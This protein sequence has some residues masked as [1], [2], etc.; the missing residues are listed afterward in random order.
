MSY[1]LGV[2]SATITADDSDFRKKLSGLEKTSNSTFKKIAGYAAAYLTFR[3]IANFFNSTIKTFSDLQEE[4]NK[5]NVVF[6]GMGASTSRI[7]AELRKDFG[8]SELAARRMLAGTGDILTGFGFDRETALALSEGAAKLGADIASFS[9]YS[10]GAEG[11]TNA[12]TKAMLGETESAKMLGVVIR[13]DDEVYKSFIQQAMTTGVK[14]EALNRTF[15]V[16]TEQQAKAVAALA[17][18][19]QQSPNAIGDFVRSQSSLANQTKILK[20]NLEQLFTV[21]GEDG[22]SVYADCLRSVNSLVRAYTELDPALRSTINSATAL[23]IAMAVLGKTGAIANANL[24]IIGIGKLISGQISLAAATSKATVALNA[25]KVAIGPVGLALAGVSAIY[26]ASKYAMD[27][28]NKAIDKN[29]DS[30]NNQKNKLEE[31]AEAHKREREESD[32]MFVSLRQM[33]E[34]ERM[35]NEDRATAE[36]MIKKLTERYGELGISID[37]TTGKINIEA[38]A[39]KKL[40]EAQYQ[41]KTKDIKKNQAGAEALLDAYLKRLV[42]SGDGDA[43]AFSDTRMLFSNEGNIN[44][45]EK[46]RNLYVAN[47]KDNLANDVNAMIGLYKQIA[48]YQRQLEDAKKAREEGKLVSNDDPKKVAETLQAVKT[49]EYDI[50]FD[51]ADAEK[52]AEM[53]SKQVQD[54]LNRQKRYVTL[55]AFMGA[56]RSKMTLQELEDL[57]EIVRLEEERRKIRER[58]EGDQRKI[59]EDSKNWFDTEWKNHNDIFNNRIKAQK[60]KQIDQQIQ[61]AQENGDIEAAKRIMEDQLTAARKAAQEAKKQY[62]QALVNA[63]ADNILTEEERTRIEKLKAKLL[64]AFGDQDKWQ[65]RLDS[66]G[67]KERENK[68][69]VGSWSLAALEAMLGSSKP[70]ERTARNTSRMIVQNEKMLNAMTNWQSGQSYR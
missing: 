65:D 12:L 15:R 46:L 59:K 54:I 40:N 32:K 67:N 35:A 9:N 3:A 28:V 43:R 53:L 30:I 61:N 60:D 1:N 27:V 4:T 56:D 7:L 48:E 36:D 10:G 62:E 37:E 51:N 22:S 13:Q 8:L 68:E 44:E 58:L 66:M 2:M 11:A 47:K 21:I 41:Q 63:E 42:S 70:E 57:K 6:Q 69:A 20:N 16:S 52:K 18:A 19:Y 55:D 38:D 25:L 5:F 50:E 34:Y 24:A 49:L 17:M 33:S 64:E 14:I 23:T 39:W 31:Q 29:V 26:L 45:L